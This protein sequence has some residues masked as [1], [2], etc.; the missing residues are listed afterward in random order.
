MKITVALN[1]FLDQRLSPSFVD[2]LTNGYEYN[3]S[4]NI[5]D[6]MKKLQ[7]TLTAQTLA[8]QTTS[9]TFEIAKKGDT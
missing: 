5:Y 6:S 9:A 1:F 8:Q 7:I 3:S 2:K 4:T